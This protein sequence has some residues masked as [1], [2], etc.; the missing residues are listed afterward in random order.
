M[1]ELP[2]V[3]AWV[4]ELDPLVSRSPI[5]KAGPAHIATLKTA[6]PPLSELDGRRF[7]G[8]R[9]RGKNLL[10][11]VEDADL[12]LRVHLM[13][14]GRL[15]YLSTGE[16]RPKTPMFRLR[17]TE[18]DELILTEG[19]K[20][21]RAGVWLVTQTQL[22]DDLGHLGPDALGL[23]AAALGEILNRDRRQLHP[24]LRDQRAIAGIGRAHSNEILLRARLSPFKASTELSDE[25][26]ERLAAAMHDD[27]DARA[28]ASR[29]GKGRR[30][31][32]PHPQPTRRAV[33]A[34]RHADRPRGLRGAHDLLLPELP[35]GRPAA[36]GSA[37][38]AP[39]AL[40]GEIWTSV[41]PGARCYGG[42]VPN[43]VKLEE[44]LQASSPE[45]ALALSRAGV[46]GVQKAVRIRRGDAKTVMAAVIDCTVDLA[47]DQKG[48]HMSR[49][50]ELFEEAIE[51]VV[52]RE[53]LLVEVLAEHIARRVVERQGALR[54]EVWIRAQWPIHRR[55][56][57]T[58]LA[59]QEMVTLC[60][61][62][63]ASEA[64]TRRAVG[65]EAT[66]INACPC[67]QG[68]VRNRASERLLEAGFEADDIEKILELVPIATH[69][70]R[71][72]Q[73]LFV[74]TEQDL[75]AEVLVDIA[76]RSMSAPIYDLLKRPDEL[77]VVEHAHLQPRF[78]E[79]SVR[80]ALRDALDTLPELD[81]DDFLLSK[82]VNFET[83]H[84]HDVVA[85]RFGTVGELRGEL[86]T[87][88][89]SPRQTTLAAWLSR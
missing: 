50:P 52:D 29:A 19:G 49:F 25:E 32:L 3:E 63:A 71:G 84:V 42:R 60:G 53:A 36:E 10:F 35:D 20:K 33:P 51:L 68:L 26:I 47:A 15:R 75:D 34:V 44:D 61:I 82:Q 9:R 66:G 43:G 22:D 13:S 40:T 23:D 39:A 31:R 18:G 2:E 1:P 74:G 8:A 14:A 11:P 85:E 76:E 87:G 21:K 6:V 16:K 46:S 17:F 38:L 73:T 30:G 70:Q 88:E 59:T 37:A 57:V 5:E 83:I 86:A 67:A 45:I 64:G 58:G 62:A 81:D 48:V 69:N 12:V 27:L 78:V 7:E 65:V 79:D 41:S 56:P 54:A 80:H 24:L 4:R 72:R 89:P 77:F 28:R 55:T